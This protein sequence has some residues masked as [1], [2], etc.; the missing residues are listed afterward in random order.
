MGQ[1]GRSPYNF[2]VSCSA[3]GKGLG[4]GHSP[5]CRKSLEKDLYTI[6]GTEQPKYVTRI[7]VS[8][9]FLLSR[10][11]PRVLNAGHLKPSTQHMRA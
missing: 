6:G 7:N 1:V 5:G 4:L 10:V 2:D 9:T 8:N 11:Q 3:G